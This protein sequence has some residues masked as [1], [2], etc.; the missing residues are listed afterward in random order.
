M[1]KKAEKIGYPCVGSGQCADNFGVLHVLT[2][3][4]PAPLQSNKHRASMFE[5]ELETR[6]EALCNLDILTPAL[7]CLTYPNTVTDGR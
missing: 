7:S 1:S 2:T 6:N 4:G 3:A 5:I